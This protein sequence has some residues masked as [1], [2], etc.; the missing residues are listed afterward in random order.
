MLLFSVAPSC[1]SVSHAQPTDQGTGR[2]L[3]CCCIW[4]DYYIGRL[5][6]HWNDRHLLRRLCTCLAKKSTSTF[7]FRVKDS[8]WSTVRSNPKQVCAAS[9]HSCPRATP[10]HHISWWLHVPPDTRLLPGGDPTTPRP[11]LCY[12]V[13]LSPLPKQSCL[14]RRNLRRHL[15]RHRATP[16]LDRSGKM[17]TLT[18]RL[19]TF[20][21]P[22]ASH[23]H[24]HTYTHAHFQRRTTCCRLHGHDRCHFC[25]PSL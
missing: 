3:C 17:A 18:F 8:C 25:N 11:S 22:L 21:N 10:H 13:S 20:G 23:A 6:F 12:G 15:L 2:A 1:N 16:K 7:F 4:T 14:Q 9:F 24:T 5:G 19:G